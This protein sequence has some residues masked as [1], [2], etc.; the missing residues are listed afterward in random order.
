MRLNRTVTEAIRMERFEELYVEL[1]AG[2]LSC[3]GA[4]MILGGTGKGSGDAQHRWKAGGGCSPRHFLR[5]RSRYDEDGLAGL[6]DRRVGRVSHRR[7]GDAEVEELTRLYRERYEGFN[8]R[9]FHE[10]ARR[11]HSLCRG[12]TWTRLVLLQAGLAT[13]CKRGG[14]HRLKALLSEVEGRPRKPPSTALQ[15]LR[16][17]MRGMMIHQDASTHRWY[18]EGYADLV[19]TL[20]DATSEITSAFFCKQEGTNSSLR[21]IH[22]TI[23]KHGL[24]CSFYTDRGSHY[25]YTPEVGGK[26]DKSRLT[27]VGRALKHLRIIHI[28]AY[29]PEA[30][31]RSERMFATLQGR[32]PGELK[33]AGITD[34]AAANR[35]LQEVYLPR[36]NAQFTV[37]PE[38]EASAFVD[39]A[40]IDIA[41][42]LCIQEDRIVGADNTVRYKAMTLQ[43]PASP[44]RHH[45]VKTHVRVHHY[46]DGSMAIFHG[47]RQ[48]G[49][50]QPS[51]ALKGEG[52]I[53]QR[54]ASPLRP[55]SGYA[56]ASPPQAGLVL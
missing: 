22:E 40:G 27:E 42:I 56:V 38:L 39:A 41:N 50:Y 23:A 8:T 10:F 15:A 30:R 5:L 29:S 51:G 32:L 45:Y 3:E 11:D 46:P 35:Y 37:A 44:Y 54:E 31:G 36:H 47:P 53:E 14:A 18:G 48:I 19:V 21:G 13:P 2:R 12:Y 28:A 6:K 55:G 24:F 33:L 9:H 34:M 43:I 20:D 52:K 49:R 7:A 16:T 1:E 4:A 26:V 25:F 17:G